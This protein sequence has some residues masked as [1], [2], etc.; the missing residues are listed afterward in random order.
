MSRET[1]LL[2]G[3]YYHVFNRSLDKR[4]IFRTDAEFHAFY[5]MLYL[6]SDGRYTNPHND[7]ML[8]A[9][10]LS[11]AEV[12]STDRE[13][14]V[15]ILSFCIL[16]NHFHLFLE[17]LCDEGISRL[18]H[19]LQR[20]YAEKFNATVNRSGSLF[21]GPF[22]AIA[23]ENEAHFLHLPRY[24]HLN[25]LDLAYPEWR[26]G[27]IDDWKKAKSVLNAYKWSSHHVFAGNGEELPLVDVDFARQ[28]FPQPEEYW[29]FL[30]KWSGRAMIPLNL[31]DDFRATP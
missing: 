2:N 23:I 28:C 3:A 25:A 30:Q 26:E 24:T 15:R 27:R 13:P 14:I 20:S 8:R 7:F 12:F 11:G 6:F 4:Q 19:K 22:K 9:Q 17:Q 21:D 10:E 29:D 18:M 5:E 16:P 1:R 31:A